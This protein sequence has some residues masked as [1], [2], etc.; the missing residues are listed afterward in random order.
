[1]RLIMNRGYRIVLT[2][3]M[4][5][6]LMPCPAA[7]NPPSSSPTPP[8]TGAAAIQPSEIIEFLS[9]TIAWYR[10]LAVEQQLATEPADLTYIQE[11]RRVAEQVLQLAFEYARAQAQVLSK[12]TKTQAQAQAPISDQYQRL[13]QGAAKADQDLQG[14]Q[15]E[16]ED[17]RQKLLKSTPANRKLLESQ[18]AELESEI[19]LIQ[20]RRDALNG[21]LEFVASSNSGV[22]SAGLRAQIEELAR[23]VPASLS[24][25]QGTGQTAISPE[26]SSPSNAVAKKVQPSGIWGLSADLI[27]L[28]AKRHTLEDEAYSTGELAKALKAFRKPILD[29]L[30]DLIHQGDQLFNAADT[31]GV[32]ELGQQRQQIDALTAQ[33]KQTSGLLLPLSKIG[34]LLDVYERSLNTWSENVRDQWHEEFRQ[35]LLRLGVLGTL[36]A[37]VFAVGEIWRRTTFRYVHD[38]RRRYQFLLLRRVLMW[39][40]IAL[41]VVFTFATQLGS[42]VTFAGLI[43][44]GVAVALQNVIVSVVAY[45]FLIGKYGIRVGDRVQIAG[46]TGEVVDIGLVRIHV[47]E[48]AGPGDSQPTGRVVALSNSIVFQPTAGLFKQIPGTNFL[49][50][51]LKLTLSPETDYHAAKER[52]SQAVEDALSEYRDSIEAQ[53]RSMEVNLTTISSADLKAKIRLHYIASG[54]EADIRYP[55]ALDQASEMDDHLMREVMAALTREPRLKLLSA[56]MPTAKVAD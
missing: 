1:M 51:E 28:S 32:S 49:W 54:I 21:M 43:T 15:K 34:V 46:V 31:A 13:A 16:L 23:S 45:F 48:L 25:P 10:Q 56:E 47:M 3:V 50:H 18:V 27:R 38:S 9:R 26:P 11:N 20:A 12:P 36:I 22:G 30:R 17:A 35:L 55:V 7:Q 14:T 53:R 5:L 4:A 42:A 39:V 24:H 44:A 40:A 29:N 6:G 19:N 33:F 8:A 52:I 2:A 37:I 41:I